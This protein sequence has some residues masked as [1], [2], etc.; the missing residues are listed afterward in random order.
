MPLR[1]DPVPY[2]RAWCRK[3]AV[4]SGCFGRISPIT[5]DSRRV[6]VLC[7]QGKWTVTPTGPDSLIKLLLLRRKYPIQSHAE[8]HVCIGCCVW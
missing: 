7:P 5:S 6:V 4:C 8:G 3:V 2:L 1:H